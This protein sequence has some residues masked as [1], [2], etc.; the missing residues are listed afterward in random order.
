MSGVVGV[1]F[2]PRD[3]ITWFDER[4]S[5]SGGDAVVEYLKAL[6]A[7]DQI[8]DYLPRTRKGDSLSLASLVR[9]ST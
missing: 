1:L 9:D 7:T 6:V 2:R 8:S 4:S 3:V 5:I